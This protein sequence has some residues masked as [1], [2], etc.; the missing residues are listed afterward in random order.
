MIPPY[1]IEFFFV[2]YSLLMRV[3]LV[4]SY[5][6]KSR[7]EGVVA[8]VLVYWKGGRGP[9]FVR[10]SA[11]GKQLPPQVRPS[12]VGN[13]DPTF[14]RTPTHPLMTVKGTRATDRCYPLGR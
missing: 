2:F 5:R 14:A 3:I 6:I 9:P 8:Q 11:A 7:E 12:A 4:V 10:S 1:V 13:H